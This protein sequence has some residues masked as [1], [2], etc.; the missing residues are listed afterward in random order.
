LQPATPKD[1]S[2]HTQGKQFNFAYDS[3]ADE[4]I[5]TQTRKHANVGNRYHQ[6]E[7][8]NYNICTKIFLYP[9]ITIIVIMLVVLE[10]DFILNKKKEKVS[11]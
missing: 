11:S 4:V 10:I 5:T 9:D 6:S 7:N 1:G 2:Q 3:N 8:E